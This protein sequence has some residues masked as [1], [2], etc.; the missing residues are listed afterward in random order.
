MKR[1]VTLVLVL[2]ASSA[3]ADSLKYVPKWRMVGD[4]A[5]Y[6]LEDAKKL[7]AL[8][9]DVIACVEK[10]RLFKADI[11]ALQQENMRMRTALE[12][13][14]REAGMWQATATEQQAAYN[15]C[16]AQKTDC[17]VKQDTPSPAWFIAGALVI[18]GTGLA[19]GYSLFH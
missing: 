18:L 3:Y 7:A 8:D 19:V 15:R 4:L 6:G 2:A 12:S 9:A 5:C 13:A 16:V 1:L 14:V 17:Q 10:E 11:E